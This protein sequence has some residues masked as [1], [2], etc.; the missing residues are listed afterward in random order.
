MLN[1]KWYGFIGEREIR[2]RT[3]VKS[4]G[5][6]VWYKIIMFERVPVIVDRVDAGAFPPGA[7]CR[8]MNAASDK[9]QWSVSGYRCTECKTL[10]ITPNTEGLEH[11]CTTKESS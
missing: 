4:D 1:Q 11:E 8:H 5:N 9:V 2:A 3:L 7:I 10:F 6:S